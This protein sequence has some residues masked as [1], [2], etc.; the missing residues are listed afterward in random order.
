MLVRDA[1]KAPEA[2]LDLTRLEA[3]LPDLRANYSSARPFPH[4]VLDDFLVPAITERAAAEFP[5]VDPDTWINYLHVNER[6]YANIDPAT[7]GPTLQTITRELMA[8]RFVAFLGELTGVDGLIIDESFEGGG[9]H[10]SVTGGFLNVHADFTVHPQHQ[11]W[12]RRVN[13][14]LYL[15]PGWPNEYGGD[16]E[17]WSTDMQRCEQKIAPIGNRAVIFNTD[18][19]AFHGHPDP[20]RCPPG[21]AR[22]SIALY[23]FTEEDHPMVRSTEYRARPGEGPRA[24]LIYL[25]KEALRAYDWVKRRLH[26][27]DQSASRLLRRLQRLWPRRKP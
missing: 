16:L 2:V 9:L 17:L 19:D 20:L 22:Q 18:A 7:W 10:Q 25:D 12:Q 8:P 11:H 26:L 27:S 14:L 1:G 15:N 13:L 23:Y 21:T 4:V 6:K 5:P 24:I 3:V